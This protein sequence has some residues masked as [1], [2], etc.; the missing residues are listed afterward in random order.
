LICAAHRG[1]QAAFG[2]L[3]AGE[4][5]IMRK[6]AILLT[7][8]LGTA[9][10]AVPSAAHAAGSPDPADRRRAAAIVATMIA[11]APVSQVAGLD[12]TNKGL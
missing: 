10:L 8:T 2:L 4:A 12:L 1:E 9:V 6:P 7:L 5:V 3:L 11:G